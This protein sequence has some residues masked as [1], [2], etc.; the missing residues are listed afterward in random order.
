V[1]QAGQDIGVVTSCPC[2]NRT[3][4][5]CILGIDMKALI[6]SDIFQFEYGTLTDDEFKPVAWPIVQ[7]M[8]QSRIDSIM[9]AT[10]ADEYQLYLTSDDKSNFRYDVATIVPYKGNR[11]ATEKPHWY[12]HIRNLLV[13]YRGAIEVFGQEADDAM[14]IAQWEDYRENV[15]SQVG[16]GNAKECQTVIC[17]RDKDLKMVPGWHYTWAAGKQ[18]EQPMWFQTEIGGLRCF[19]KQLLTGDSTDNIPGLY[20]VGKS[21]TLLKKLD[22]MDTELQMYTHV[23]E[24]Y[25]L[26][27]GSY[28]EQFLIENG[29]LLHMRSY[30]GE[31]WLP[32]TQRN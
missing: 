28:A 14:A 8:I 1:A 19:Y 31:M 3:L 17:S 32:P 7:N 4:W 2:P 21:S 12:S 10:G 29:R 22:D 18:K 24:Q 9:E 23:L 16:L 15:L 25:K 6:D 26:R 11:A 13:D 5:I 27:F 30:E 20:G